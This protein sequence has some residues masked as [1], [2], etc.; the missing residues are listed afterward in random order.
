MRKRE[1]AFARA[2]I[3]VGKKCAA[4]MQNGGFFNSNNAIVSTLL[5]YQIPL[6]LL[7]YYAGDV[8]DRTFSTTGSLTEPVLQALGIRYY[9]DARDRG[10]RGTDSPGANL[11]RR[12]ET[13]GGAAADQGVSRPPCRAESALS[14]GRIFPSSIR[15]VKLCKDLTVLKALAPLAGD[16][17]VVSSAGAVTLE[18]NALRPSDG[19]F[20][21]RTLGLCSSIALGMALGLPRAQN[22]R[23]RRRWVAADESMLAADDRAHETEKSCSISFSTMKSTKLRAAKKPR[24]ARAR[25]WSGWRAPPVSKMPTGQTRW[26]PLHKR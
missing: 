10:R 8:G 3:L 20:R 25:I 14:D 24:P 4:I 5:Q 26:M 9:V 6:L 11:D 12:F 15:R 1:S 7:I 17:L 22:H 13:T 16:A 21:V 23:A 18:W 19:N 2:L